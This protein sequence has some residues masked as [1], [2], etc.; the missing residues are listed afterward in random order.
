M[1]SCIRALILVLSASGMVYAQQA[2]SFNGKLT[3]ILHRMRSS[4]L[5]TRAGAFSDFEVLLTEGIDMNEYVREHPQDAQGRDYWLN[6]FLALHP[7]QAER[8]K[9]GLI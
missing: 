1:Q 8:I 5:R 2:P 7:D 9:L 3:I 6:R 4:D